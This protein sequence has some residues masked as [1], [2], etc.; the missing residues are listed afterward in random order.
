MSSAALRRTAAFF[1]FVMLLALAACSS[2]STRICNAAGNSCCG[3][4]ND[5]CVAPQFVYAANV[6]GQ[7][8][9]F[10]VDPA[11]GGLSTP[12][13]VTAPSGSWGMAVFNNSFLYLSNPQLGGYG[14]I[15]GW[16]ITPG[17]GLLTPISASPF[18][19][20]DSL[21]FGMAVDPAQNMLY[22]A[23]ADK[24]R[25]LRVD[26]MTGIPTEI[27]TSPFPAGLNMYLAI[28]PQ[29]RFLF[30]ADQRSPGS[31]W[32]YAID[33][34]GNLISVPGSPFAADPN[35]SSDTSPY[36]IVV[37]PSGSFVYVALAGTDQVAAFSITPDTGVLSPVAGSPFTAG[38]TPSQLV[39][40]NQ[41]LYVSNSQDGTISGYSINANGSL[42]PIA[43]SPFNFNVSSLTTNFTGSVLYGSSSQGMLALG[44]G[45][46][47]GTLSMIGSPVPFS[48]G[49]IAMAFLQ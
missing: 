28:D 32:A 13:T 3:A 33:A 16:T 15:S 22:V 44:I 34:S 47:S 30:A 41:F 26:A 20:D 48:P 46:T 9:T 19:L 14:S 29:N 17:E 24:I 36:G 5:L 35:A 40:A 21:P 12:T 37:D 27:A 25:A 39:V 49:A 7:L 31:V 6:D 2:S 4:G 11:T 45:S 23:D 38:G 42:R 43:G 10:P 18:Q 1:L 8:S